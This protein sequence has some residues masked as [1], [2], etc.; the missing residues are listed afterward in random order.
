MQGK[1]CILLAKKFTKASP[2]SKGEDIDNL[3]GERP[4]IN[5]RMKDCS[6]FCNLSYPIIEDVD[7]VKKSFPEESTRPRCFTGK[8]YQTREQINPII[9]D[10]FKNR[11]RETTPQCIFTRLVKPRHQNLIK[12]V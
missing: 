10:L 2:D 8:F 7:S 12:T 11:K 6:H 9:Q 4:Y 5:R 3:F 1:N